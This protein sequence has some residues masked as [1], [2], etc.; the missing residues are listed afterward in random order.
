MHIHSDLSTGLSSLLTTLIFIG[1]AA[2]GIATGHLSDRL[3]RRKIL[4]VTGAILSS[5]IA[6]AIALTNSAPLW[7]NAML[8]IALGLTT[9][10]QLLAFM[11]TADVAKRH[12]RAVKL[13]FVNFVVMV[14][15][16]FI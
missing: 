9:G 10:S 7:W 5:V 14:L 8:M 13:A 3:K 4:F 6:V 11:M 12:N 15:P 1:F 16:V 2:G